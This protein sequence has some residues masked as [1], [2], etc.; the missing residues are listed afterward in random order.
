MQTGSVLNMEIALK[1]IDLMKV[2]NG[3]NV[4]ERRIRGNLIVLILGND[5]APIERFIVWWKVQNVV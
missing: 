1:R 4:V 2:P 5:V 3:I